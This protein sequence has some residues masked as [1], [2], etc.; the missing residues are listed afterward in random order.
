MSLSSAL[1]S[2]ALKTASTAASQSPFEESTQSLIRSSLADLTALNARIAGLS[3]FSPNETLED[4]STRDLIYLTAPF[5]TSELQSRVRVGQPA[6]DIANTLSSNQGHLSK[7]VSSLE[8]YEIVP[9]AERALHTQSLQIIKDA[10]SRRELKIKQFQQERDLRNKIQ[11]IRKRRGQLPAEGVTESD[12]DLIAS[13]LPKPSVNDEDEDEDSEWEDDLRETTLL[14]LRLCYAQAQS[15]LVSF[16]Q[17]L[18]MLEKVVQFPPQPPR[19]PPEQDRRGKERS[20]DESMWKLDSPSGPDGKGPI[21]DAQNKPL[22]PF[23]L[24]PSGASDRARLAGQVF[25]PSHRLPTMTVDE[26]LQI[27]QEQGKFISGGGPASENELT[28]SEQLDLD[29]QMD[30]TRDGAEKEETKR[31][32]DEKWAQFTDANPRGAGNTMNRG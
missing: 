8:D 19:P 27:E 15:Q 4:I 14:L 11:V 9:E 3:L 5:A 18:E 25:G 21:L 26:L 24:L 10:A 6:D 29:S 32:K 30:G 13:L 28:S 7:L 1:F 22:R 16:G 17:Q 20:A 2:Q 12:L 23:T 31:Q